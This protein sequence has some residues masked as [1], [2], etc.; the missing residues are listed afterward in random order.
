MQSRRFALVA[1]AA[2]A[3]TILGAPVR[4]FA[5]EITIDN[6]E[7]GAFSSLGGSMIQT[8]LSTTNVISGERRVS[9]ENAT[10]G[11]TLTGGD[12][13]IDFMFDPQVPTNAS[14]TLDYQFLSSVVDLTSADRF[15]VDLP[16]VIGIVDFVQLVVQNG[17][18]SVTDITDDRTVVLRQMSV[19]GP[20]PIVFLF[21]DFVNESPLSPGPLDFANIDRIR[22]NL[23]AIRPTSEGTVQISNFAAVPEPSTAALLAA[24][25][26]TL[27]IR[28]RGRR[29]AT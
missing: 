2:V 17:F 29:A 3:A 16:Q 15:V 4:S 13:A 23:L 14:I 10:A 19:S 27:G 5:A 24:G 12:D 7:E 11:L 1:F 25:L 8:G 26:L 18:S 21:A 28:R 6:F 22:L 20:G 9:V